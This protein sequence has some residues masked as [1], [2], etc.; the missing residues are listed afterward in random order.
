MN[1]TAKIVS[2]YFIFKFITTMPGTVDRERL[3]E[4]FRFSPMK[5]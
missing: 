1:V 5:G 4:I 3:P 2:Y